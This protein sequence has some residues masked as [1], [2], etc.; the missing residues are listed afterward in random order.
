M[1]NLIKLI[2]GSTAGLNKLMS[3][4]RKQWTSKCLGREITDEEVDEKSP[5]SKRQ[6][7]KRIQNIATKERRTDRLRWYVHNHVLT[8]FGLEN[9]V[10]ADGLNNSDATTDSAKVPVTH[11]P[12]TPSIMQFAR[13]VSPALHRDT[14]LELKHNT[15]KINPTSVPH[16]STSPM[17][18]DSTSSLPNANNSQPAYI[19]GFSSPGSSQL[20][21]H[22]NTVTSGN[23]QICKP[24]FVTAATTTAETKSTT[25]QE[26]SSGKHIKTVSID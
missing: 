19:S 17:E 18:V 22:N 3:H 25:S 9:L 16:D 5:I 21:A 7:E 1:P 6:L 2:H 15:N 24:T 10:V 20:R 12:N 26:L 23:S 13:P 11:C 8:S 14:S 4:F